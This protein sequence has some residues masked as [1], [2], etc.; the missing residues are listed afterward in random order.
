VA[1]IFATNGEKFDAT[2]A[3]T[4]TKSNVNVE[5]AEKDHIEQNT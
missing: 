5:L 3:L 2:I 1:D 4:A